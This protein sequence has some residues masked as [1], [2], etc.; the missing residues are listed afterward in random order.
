MG[1][2]KFFVA[3]SRG[4][5]EPPREEGHGCSTQAAHAAPGLHFNEHLDEA[6]SISGQVASGLNEGQRYGWLYAPTV[7][8]G[9]KCALETRN[10]PER[11]KLHQP[12][13]W[14]VLKAVQIAHDDDRATHQPNAF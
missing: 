8:R 10:V 6:E 12:I 11:L 1:C 9:G 14:P 4:H 2:R 5:E 3:H 13:I 7:I